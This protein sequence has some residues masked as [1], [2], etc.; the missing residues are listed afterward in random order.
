M[1]RDANYLAVGVFTLLVIAMGVAFVLWYGDVNSGSESDR[2]EIY[3][4]G[5]VSGL[6][7]GG[8]VRYLGVDVGNVQRISLSKDR[9]DTVKVVVDVDNNAPISGATRASL[10][11]QGVTGLLYINLKQAEDVGAAQLRNG[12]RYPVIESQSSNI[13]ALLATL[14]ELV[15]RATNLLDR[16]NALLSDQNLGTVGRTLENLR[17]T[18]EK[19][20]DTTR[21]VDELLAQFTATAA[22]IKATAANVNGAVNDTRPELGKIMGRL[23]QVSED[24]ART[25]QRLDSFVANTETQVSHFSDQGLFEMERLLRDARAAAIEFRE[26]SRSLKETPSQLLF[27]RP[28]T[29]VEIKP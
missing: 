18:T 5:S 29:G 10:G 2:Y 28:E 8:P 19:F 9:P 14:P 26:L 13:D 22:E 11:L 1:E 15:G 6:T 7:V 27:E 23:N 3:F 20:P 21:R 12:E 17:A 16:A 4:A 24:L 25:T